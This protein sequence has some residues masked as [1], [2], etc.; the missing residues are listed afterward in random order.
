MTPERIDKLNEIG[1][2]WNRAFDVKAEARLKR[3][4]EYDG[5]SNF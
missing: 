2:E 3:S 5:P 4:D 1:F